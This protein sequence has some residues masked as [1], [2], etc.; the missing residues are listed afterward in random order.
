MEASTN[1]AKRTTTYGG[2]GLALIVRLGPRLW[3]EASSKGGC[4]RPKKARHTIG[5]L[6]LRMRCSSEV[7]FM[8]RFL[9]PKL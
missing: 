5:G 6:R 3:K 4:G 2:V 1:V 7:E 8:A 9:W